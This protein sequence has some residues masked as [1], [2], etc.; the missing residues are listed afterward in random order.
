MTDLD[1][2]ALRYSHQDACVIAKISE[3]DLANWVS[4]SF[5]LGTLVPSGDRN[6]RRYSARDLIVLRNVTALAGPPACRSRLFLPP[7]LAYD[8]AKVIATFGDLLVRDEE[9]NVRPPLPEECWYAC[10]GC[11]SDDSGVTVDL[12]NAAQVAERLHEVSNQWLVIPASRLAYETVHACGDAKTKKFPRAVARVAQSPADAVDA[13][14]VEALKRDMIE[15]VRA[16]G[17][18]GDDE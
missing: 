8:A 2:N 1:L 12:W 11:D 13:V 10:V 15:A 4:C 16:K 5:P 7:A 9:G 18:L 14:A 17:L 6:F 3:K